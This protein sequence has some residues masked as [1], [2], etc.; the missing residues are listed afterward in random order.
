[1]LATRR[2]GIPTRSRRSSRSG[3]WLGFGLAGL[4]NVLNPGL[5][6]LGG[7]FGRIYPFVARPRGASWTGGPCAAPRGLVRVVPATLGVDAPLLGRR[8][9]PSSRSS[10]TRPR[11]LGRA[12]TLAERATA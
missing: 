1:M 4:V 5:V 3:R 11:W 2:P 6:V 7:L 9:S 8:S 10:P 12:S